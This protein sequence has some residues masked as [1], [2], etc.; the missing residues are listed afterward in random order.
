MTFIDPDIELDPGFAEVVAP[1]LAHDDVLSMRQY[2]HHDRTAL[3]HSIAVAA[4]SYSLAKRLKLDAVSTAR[5]AL[6]H[7]FFLYD[8]RDGNNPHHPTRH[9]R[10]ALRNARQ[11]FELNPVEEDIIVTHMW[12]VGRPFYAYP[13]SA[14]VSLVDKLVSTRELAILVARILRVIVLSMASRLAPGRT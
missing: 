14:L 1:L 6:L 7:D 2:R 11:R 5:G 4:G 13:E 9:A 10:V 3:G 8:W 12:P